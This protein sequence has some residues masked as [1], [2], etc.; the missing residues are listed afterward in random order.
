MATLGN[1]FLTKTRSRCTESQNLNDASAE[2]GH[3]GSAPPPGI[4][5]KLIRQMLRSSGEGQESQQDQSLADM[6]D[7]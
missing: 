2:P 6:T 4:N 7:N 3:R 5:N 1:D